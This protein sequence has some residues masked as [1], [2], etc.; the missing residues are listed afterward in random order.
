M[1]KAD[2]VSFSRRQLLAGAAASAGLVGSAAFVWWMGTQIFAFSVALFW[3]GSRMPVVAKPRLTKDPNSMSVGES[4]VIALRT[5]AEMC[6]AGNMSSQHAG[7][8]WSRVQP[9]FRSPV[10]LCQTK[11]KL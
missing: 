9:L 8:P 2:H 4:E 10:V 1:S 3:F 7:G 5:F 11:V 6:S